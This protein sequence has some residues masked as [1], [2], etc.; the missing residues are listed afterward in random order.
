[1]PLTKD[2]EN[3]F[4]PCLAMR[5]TVAI[6]RLITDFDQ[7][8]THHFQH[9]DQHNRCCFASRMAAVVAMGCLDVR[10]LTKLIPYE[11][12]RVEYF[13]VIPFLM[14]HSYA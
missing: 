9:K 4:L 13:N 8:K 3:L 6:S 7:K 14:D 2:N 11:Y 12:L 5:S 10:A 1:M